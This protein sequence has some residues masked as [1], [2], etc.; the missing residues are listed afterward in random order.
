MPN[1]VEAPLAVGQPVAELKVR[2]GDEE[3]LSAPLRALDDN[4][5]G[6]MWQ[7]ARDSVSLMF[8]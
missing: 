8:E 6:S 5:I 3:L 1:I 7:Q 4:P 2:L